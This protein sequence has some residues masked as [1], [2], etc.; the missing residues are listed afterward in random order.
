MQHNDND[1][2]QTRPKKSVRRIATTDISVRRT[3]NTPLKEVLAVCEARP[4]W[5][6]VISKLTEGT[7]AHEA[8]SF[9]QQLGADRVLAAK[10]DA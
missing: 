3:P 2:K 6:G 8:P 5:R 4:A 1:N 10:S 9:L 7:A